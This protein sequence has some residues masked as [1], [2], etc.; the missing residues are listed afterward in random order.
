M[1]RN[2]CAFSIDYF[3]SDNRIYDYA[4]FILWLRGY[5]PV[6]KEVILCDE[7]YNHSLVMSRGILVDDI[8]GLLE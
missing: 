1:E 8:V 4:K 3:N 2:R 5:F 7:S 6:G